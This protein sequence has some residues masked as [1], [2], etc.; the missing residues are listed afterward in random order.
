MRV[1]SKNALTKPR[2]VPK[3]AFDK[4]YGVASR[5]PIVKK[6][7]KRRYEFKTWKDNFFF[8][9]NSYSVFRKLIRG[10]ALIFVARNYFIS[11]LIDNANLEKP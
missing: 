2:C 4:A 3:A 8:Q 7:E 5:P 9:I 6:W 11:T 1:K 10:K